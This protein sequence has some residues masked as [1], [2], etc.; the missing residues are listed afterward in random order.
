MMDACNIV[1]NDVLH[2]NAKN[3]APFLMRIKREHPDHFFQIEETVRQVAPFF[4]EF[5]LK[6]DGTGQ[7]TQLL[8]RD[9]FCESIYYPFQ[10]SD[11]T[12]RYI[13]L[14]TLLLQPDPPATIILDEPESGLHPTEINLL[15]GML[16]EAGTRT[17][18]IVATQSS[19]L[20][21][22]LEPEQVIVVNHANGESIL[23][24]LDPRPLQVPE[25]RGR[26]ARI[27]SFSFSCSFSFSGLCSGT[28]CECRSRSTIRNTIRRT[29]KSRSTNPDRRKR[30]SK[31]TRTIPGVARASRP[32]TARS[33][34][35][36]PPRLPPASLPPLSRHSIATLPDRA[37]VSKSPCLDFAS[38]MSRF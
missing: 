25:W 32:P 11:G 27:N 4:R 20:V 34:A 9:R 10:L 17:Q 35:S 38:C 33:A 30:T 16:Q 13:C 18:L 7:Q 5:V 29:R 15:S 28:S 14:A 26:L 2:G 3:I 22:N 24:R 1:D 31:R 36:M 12:L 37:I 21:D 23:R 19:L 8:W 6:P